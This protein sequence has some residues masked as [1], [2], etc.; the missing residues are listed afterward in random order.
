[1]SKK[2]LSTWSMVKSFTKELS[3]YISE[4]APNVSIKDYAQRVGTC[5]VCEYFKKKNINSKIAEYIKKNIFKI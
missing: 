5:E 1:M 4:G 3:R 2:I